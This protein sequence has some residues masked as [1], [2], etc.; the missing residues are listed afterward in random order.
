[1]PRFVVEK[2]RE[3]LNL[4]RKAVNGSRILVLGVAYKRDVDDVRES[5]AIDVI[6]LLEADG[7][8]VAYHD[9]FVASVRDDQR[10]WTSVELDEWLDSSDAVV[11]V[12]DH[13][14][15]DYEE[16]LRRAR[17]LVDTRNATVGLASPVATRHPQRWIV[18]TEGAG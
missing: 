8:E 6:K 14:C 18:K 1:M 2:V 3:A 5:P 12:T 9:P 10:E 4:L 16:I 13:S 7:A 17:V 11:I 15:F